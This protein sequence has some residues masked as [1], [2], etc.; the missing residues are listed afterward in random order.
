VGLL[1]V[2]IYVIIYLVRTVSFKDRIAVPATICAVAIIAIF[3]ALKEL[4]AHNGRFA[5]D[6][7]TPDTGF[8]AFTGYPVIDIGA[9]E[10]PGKE[11]IAGDVNGD[12]YVDWEDFAIMA[13]HWLEGTK[14][15]SD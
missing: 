10:Y 14:L 7:N 12:G 5:D 6:P 8:F 1:I 9:Y 11:P 4:I 2:A 15:K 3:I 13:S